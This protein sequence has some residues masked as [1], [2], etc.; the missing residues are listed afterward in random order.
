VFTK[1]EV[2]PDD[3]A[4]GASKRFGLTNQTKILEF[5]EVGDF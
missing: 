3:G 5:I 4:Q 2:V 1:L